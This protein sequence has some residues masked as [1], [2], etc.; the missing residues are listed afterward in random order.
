MVDYYPYKFFINFTDRF[1][2]LFSRSLLPTSSQT[3]I[4]MLAP[5]SVIINN[6]SF[7]LSTDSSID[8]DDQGY[9]DTPGGEIASNRAGKD[10]TI[11]GVYSDAGLSFVL[12]FNS[13]I[14][15]G[16]TENT[17]RKIGGFHC[18]CVDVGTISGHALTGLLAGDILPASVWDLEHRP[19]CDPAGMVYSDQA[20]LWVDIYL[21]SG[22]GAATA[23]AYGAT[24]TD[25]RIWMDHV[26][27]LAAV[28]KRLLWDGE[29]QIIAEGSN[30]KTNISG[31]ADP[32]TTGGHVDAADRRMIS[33]IGCEDCCGVMYQ[34]LMDTQ[35]KISSMPDTGDPA[36]GW[37]TLPGNKG[38]IYR[39]GSS[40]DTKLLSGGSWSNGSNCGSRCRSAYYVRWD[41][42]S[43]FG[44]RGCARSKGGVV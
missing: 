38:S 34:W 8:L 10:V 17:S 16:Y 18:L 3:T 7:A 22:T 44:A 5:L 33:N 40:G 14:P 13:T 43:S 9:W 11:F 12:S 27:D 26:D 15:F 39:Q 23:S 24:I 20:D 41:A 42:S 2:N 6:L 29:F 31:S 35:F 32:V 1:P 28:G 25:T 21:Q 37:Y 19:A 36:F 4:T 30:Q